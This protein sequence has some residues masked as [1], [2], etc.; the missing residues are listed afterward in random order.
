MHYNSS[1]GYVFEPDAPMKK[2]CRAH[3]C[4]TVPIMTLAE[5]TKTQKAVAIV[6]LYMAIKTNAGFD[7]EVI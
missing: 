2:T 3:C 6:L 4:M 5:A 1:T 7:F